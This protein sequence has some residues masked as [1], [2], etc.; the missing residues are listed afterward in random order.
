MYKIMIVDDEAMSANTLKKYIDTHLPSC[1][2]VGT[3][4]NGQEA[5]DAL[6]R[7]STRLNSSH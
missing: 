2:V 7:K 1:R 3:Y 5:L 6:D 4:R